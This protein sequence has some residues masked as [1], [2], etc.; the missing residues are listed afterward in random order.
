MSLLNY[1]ITGGSID[2]DQITEQI[3]RRTNS[4]TTPLHLAIVGLESVAFVRSLI[5]SGA[6]VNAK[7]NYGET[8]LHW[9]V[10]KGNEEIL[11]AL[12]D[13]GA[14]VNVADNGM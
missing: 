5:D 13:E 1:C 3:A 9:C 10:Q 6:E 8:P 11:R 14:D 4:G 2:P 7:N 12:L